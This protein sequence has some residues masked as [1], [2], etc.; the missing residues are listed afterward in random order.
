MEKI[1]NA[2]QQNKDILLAEL[3]IENQDLQK[4][5]AAHKESRAYAESKQQEAYEELNRLKTQFNSFKVENEDVIRELMSKDKQLDIKSV[6]LLKEKEKYDKLSLKYANLQ[7]SINS[8]EDQRKINNEK[9]HAELK[10]LEEK[11]NQ[12]LKT[13]DHFEQ[14]ANENSYDNWK[15][16]FALKNA[17]LGAWDYNED[18]DTF[19]FSQAGCQI[20]GYKQK[21]MERDFDTFL[22]MIHQGDKRLFREKFQELRSQQIKAVEIDIRIIDK[23]DVYQNVHF[24]ASYYLNKKSKPRLAGVISD[25]DNVTLKNLKNELSELSLLLEEK[26]S[27]IEQ[28]RNVRDQLEESIKKL[29]SDFENSQGE[30]INAEE[31]DKLQKNHDLTSK[32]LNE[33]KVEFEI[34]KEILGEKELELKEALQRVHKT[35]NDSPSEFHLEEIENLKRQLNQTRAEYENLSL[36]ASKTDNA[37]IITDHEG[38]IQYVNKGFE[39]LTEYSK[40]EVI[41][42][43]PGNFL[44]GENTNPEHVKAIR[45]GLNSKKPFSQDIINYSKSGKEY[46]LSIS[47][48]PIFDENGTLDKFIA[49]E[50]DVTEDKKR[51]EE[52]QEAESELRKLMEDQ[53]IQSEQLIIKEQ[54]L[55]KA[56][57]ESERIREEVENL[58]MVASKT[59][60]AVVITDPLGQILYVNEGFERI[61]EYKR[62][63]VLGKKPGSFLQGPDTDM[64]HV[65]A[66]RQGLNSKKP[67]KQDILNYSKTGRPYWLNISINPVFNEAGEIEK[68]IAI[69]NDIT[70]QKMQEEEFKNLSL[71][72]SRTDNAVIISDR[73]GCIEWVNKGFERIT[74]YTLEEVKGKKPG[75]FL[76][77]PETSREDILAISQGIKSQK[78]FKHEIYNYSKSGRGYWLSLSITPV[79]N[80]KGILD[81]FIAIESDITEEKKS[82]E[83][84]VNLS[85]V[86]SRTDNAVIISDKYG[87]IEWVNDGFTRITEYT[88]TEVKGKKPGSFLQGE[89]TSQE[90][91]LAIRRGINSKKPFKHEIYNYSK[92]GRGYWLS[93]SITPIFDE[94]GELDKFIAIENDITAQKEL[95]L[96]LEN[97]SLVASKTDNAVIISDKDGL[98]EWVNPF[99]TKLT[100]YSLEEVKGKKPGSF[101]QGPDTREEDVIAIRKGIKSQKPF[102]AEIYN[103]SKSGRE[104]WLSLSITP[105]FDEYGIV[106]KFIAIERDITVEKQLAAEIEDSEEQM[107]LLMEDQFSNQEDLLN[108]EAE[109]QKAL[110]ESKIL[111]LV[112]SKTDNA[113]V[114]TNKDGLV[115]YVNDGFVRIT[116]YKLEEVAGKKPGTFLQGPDTDP[117]HVQAIREGLLSK[118]PFTQ[119]IINYSKNGKPYWLS[120]SIT[121]ILDEE[122]EVERFIAIESDIS[123]RKANEEELQN[124]SLVASKTDNA[125]IITNNKGLIEWVNPGFENLT[126]YS[127]EEVVGKK[128]GNILQGKETTSE[129][130][131]AI[132][133]GL[134]SLEP[135]TAEIYN[136]SKSGRGYWLSLSITPIFDQ[137]GNV[138]KFIAIESD[139]TER[140][141]LE[142][143]IAETEEQMRAIM[144]EQFATTEALMK[145]DM[146]LNE[147][148]ASSEELMKKEEALNKALAQE[149]KRKQELDEALARIKETQSQMVQNEKMASLGQLTAGIAHEINN[150][151]N[152]VYNGI[153]S[154]N[155]SLEDLTAIIQKY[156]DLENCDPDEVDHVLEE[157]KT[158]KKRLRFEK[159]MKNLPSVLSDIKNGANRTI[160]IV[161]G[162]RVFSRLD[163]E[164]QKAADINECLN[165]TLI[166]LRNKTKDRVEVKKYFDESL[167]DIMCYPGQLNQ[168]FMNL[169]SNAV[170]A[171]P[172]EKKDGK[173]M[174]Y[175]ENME[176]R[177]II[178]VLDNGSGIPEDVKEKVFEPFFTTKGVGIGTGLGLSISYGII[179]KHDGKIYVNS[180]VGKG[181]EFVIELPKI[182]KKV[183]KGIQK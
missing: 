83:E 146:E 144:D 145:K 105:I 53:F 5:I 55:S 94:Y 43:K 102:T 9:L 7:S 84:L 183:I 179:E 138:E 88:L 130:I 117:K 49:V 76:Q 81:K 174:L 27:Q 60:N 148:N 157:I 123:E 66:I 95:Q 107:R 178:R 113:V 54:E 111:S 151:I 161:K 74:E 132:R 142:L 59:D 154:L 166:L 86:A 51:D 180:E 15:F 100:E 165:S 69:E 121:P 91:I 126:E 80:D 36:V 4:T 129:Q 109:L 26:D 141:T 12:L 96:E 32:E 14:K 170:Q 70:A 64:E 61:T 63:E 22:L 16:N 1:Q 73:Y 172:E 140:K 116:G 47:I 8:A 17:K 168:V 38:K 24:S 115:E 93:L 104:Y 149:K 65:K 110:D 6:T 29:K 33:L 99:F 20:L 2:G 147:A 143:E 82:Q 176:D 128:P 79:F 150:P 177:V 173:I 156:S 37:I 13:I 19:T 137:F 48:T 106:E 52:L 89:K 103:Y 153:D 101:L 97:L 77:G 135:F 92:S 139:I 134:Q 67:F 98:I 175:T 127:F 44:Q 171:I 42:E 182:N 23:N 133:M 124:L 72:A 62:E 41:G 158:M 87:M 35:D 11:Y 25:Q 57:E 131:T 71:V 169:L 90:D 85:L 181:T 108:K 75:D 45:E 114:V 18:K 40:E 21:S 10:E 28:E 68:F 159:L 152:F 39:R 56:L 31:F 160:E 119:E 155:M 78:P 167:E 162:L 118:K 120:L 50:R 112:A 34:T 3:L 136:Y 30:T 163:E 58:S 122:G 125:V 164:E 46:W